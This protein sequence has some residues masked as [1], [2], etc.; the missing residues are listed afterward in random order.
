MTYLPPAEANAYENQ[1]RRARDTYEGTLAGI[2]QQRGDA[3]AGNAWNV[4]ELTRRWDKIRTRL[5]GQ[6]IAR[7]LQNSGI[8]KRGM[9]EYAVARNAAQQGLALKYQQ[10]VH[11]YDQQG[12][13]AGI[14]YG[15]TVGDT[16]DQ[17]AIRR[18]QIAAALT[19]L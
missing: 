16:Y 12:L 5:P 2:T 15:N 4:G 17:E 18:S 7:G 8:Q 9:G 10:M 1:R 3:A 6:Y 19:G 14:I 13:G 11:Q